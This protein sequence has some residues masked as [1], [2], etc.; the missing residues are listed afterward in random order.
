[1]LCLYF[2]LATILFTIPLSTPHLSFSFSAII[3]WLFPLSD[4]KEEE[5]MGEGGKVEGMESG[6]K[7]ERGKGGGPCP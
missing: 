5:R 1:M 3:Q 7:G 6:R 4:M 2:L